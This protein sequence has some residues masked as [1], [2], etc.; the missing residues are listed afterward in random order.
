MQFAL[1]EKCYNYLKMKFKAITEKEYQKFWDKHPQKTFLSSVEIGKLRKQNGFGVDFLGVFDED[2]LVAAAMVTSKVRRF[3]KKDFYCPRGPLMDY[4][5]KELVEYFIEKLKDFA[6][7]NGGYGLRIDPYVIKQ[8]RDINGD[9]VEG[10]EDN[11]NAIDNLKSLGFKKVPVARREQVA[12]MFSL[13][14]DGKTEDQIM[15][16]MSSSTRQRVRRTERIGIDIRELKKD[17]LGA[18]QDILDETAERKSFHSRDLK[19]HED[20]YDLFGD[21]VKFF[22]TSLDL[23]K[24]SKKLHAELDEKNEQLSKAKK[25]GEKKNIEKD[26]VS[27]NLKL[28]E[29]DEIREKTGKKVINLSSSM[30]VLMQ[31]EVIYLESGNYNQYMKFNA[32]YLIQWELIKYGIKHGF[33]KHNFYGIPD[34]INTHPKDFGIYE[35]KKGFNGYVEELI[36]EYELPVSKEYYMLHAIHKTRDLV[37]KAKKIVKR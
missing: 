5:N 10:G 17:E 2:K 26:I 6:K 31:P 35:F 28:K 36:G 21:Q 27:L 7:K 11:L 14:I 9:I 33:K 37:Q 19:Y 25:E 23:D 20:M 3:N 34:E 13:D 16:E 4:N 30:F 15:K 18:F 22:I 24:Y 12:W 8:Q 32:Q 1:P 29:A